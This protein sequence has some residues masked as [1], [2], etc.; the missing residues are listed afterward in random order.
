[1]ARHPLSPLYGVQCVKRFLLRADAVCWTRSGTAS[2]LS[3]RRSAAPPCIRSA[4]TGCLTTIPRAWAMRG[5]E[6]GTH[7]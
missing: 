4:L 6:S 7:L 5:R 1:M 2:L 3:G